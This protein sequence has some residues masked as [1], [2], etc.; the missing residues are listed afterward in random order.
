MTPTFS[1]GKMK[2]M[3]NTFVAVAKEFQNYFEQIAKKNQ[4][5][6]VR[7]VFSRF[8]IDVIGNCAFGIE[9]NT[10]KQPDTE[11]RRV[12]DIRRNDFLSLLIDI[13]NTGKLRGDDTDLGKITLEELVAQT[14]VFFIAGYSTSSSTLT[15]AFYELAVNQDIQ[16]KARGEVNR[17]LEKYN[18]EYTYE[19]CMEMKYIDQIIKETLRKHTAIDF[20]IRSCSQDYPVPG[21][22]HVIEKGTFLTIPIYGIH[23]DPEIY[24]DP[25]KFDPERFAEENIKNRHP[26]AWLPFGEGP[27]NCIAIKFGMMQTKIALA[28]FLSK[29]RVDISP[30]TVIPPILDNLRF[31]RSP[32]GD[33]TDLG[34]I[35][36]EEPATK[37]FLFFIAAYDTS[38]STMTFALY[39]LALQQDIQEKARE[40][41]NRILKKYNG[42]YTYEACIEMKYIDQIIK[43]T[44][45]KHPVVDFI[46]R[47]CGQ[48]YPVPGTKHII[49][50]GTFITIPV[51]GIH[52]DPEIYPNPDKFDPERF[53][54]ENIK[55]RHAC[56]WLPFGEGPR[57]CIGMKFGMMQV[58]IGLAIFLSKYKVAI[59]PETV[60]PLVLKKITCRWSSRHHLYGSILK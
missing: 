29:Y 40:E 42:E 54:E 30:E 31:V 14:F 13:K 58:K 6:E 25:E 16:E 19:A 4:T 20:L 46:A 60:I 57:N 32:K 45:R 7:D 17:I 50:K 8:T 48:D 34:K 5:I 59:S 10:L 2:M 1:S 9:C 27:R 52:H 21:T 26:F 43:E 23:H 47:I 28:V 56:A 39:E 22:S 36:F 3:H 35:T 41:V 37:R 33:D 15:F 12:N 44:L 51:Y 38:S 11:F 18:G 55:N 53:T 49:E 24:P